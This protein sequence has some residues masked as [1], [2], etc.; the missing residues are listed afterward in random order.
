MLLDVTGLGGSR[1]LLARNLAVLVGIDLRQRR[2]VRFDFGAFERTRAVFVR[3]LELRLGAHVRNRSSRRR[4]LCEGRA[5][6]NRESNEG[7][8][9]KPMHHVL[10]SR[11]ITPQ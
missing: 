11:R 3:R 8:S 4:G 7:T 6:S 9:E 5:G 2:L 1:E 10:Q